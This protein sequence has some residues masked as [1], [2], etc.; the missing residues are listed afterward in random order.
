MDLALLQSA[1]QLCLNF[2][3][4]IAHLVEEQ[5]APLGLLKVTAGGTGGTGIGTLGIAKKQRR[6]K[7]CRYCS[8]ID[9]HQG[10][11]ASRTGTMQRLRHQFLAR[12]GLTENQYVITRTGR[13]GDLRAQRIHIKTAAH[14]G[15]GDRPGVVN[16]G[17]GGRYHCSAQ[18]QNHPVRQENRN[19]GAG[20]CGGKFF[21]GNQLMAVD[22]ASTG[23]VA[24]A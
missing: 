13:P 3:G 18:Q 11:A 17:R 1:Q 5:G 2:S 4:G 9:C 19:T 14:H 22:P 20:I 6:C 16:R 21:G 10:R 7:S 8:H 23:P 15:T 24:T 12:A